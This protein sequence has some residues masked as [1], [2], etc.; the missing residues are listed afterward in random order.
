[1]A[2][3]KAL[4]RPIPIF[5][6]SVKGQD[7]L[8]IDVYIPDPRT[9]LQM[10]RQ[11]VL[12]VLIGADGVVETWGI[13]RVVVSDVPKGEAKDYVARKHTTRPT[14]HDREPEE[15]KVESRQIRWWAEVGHPDNCFAVEY[16]GMKIRILP[17]EREVHLWGI[18]SLEVND[19]G[20]TH[21]AQFRAL[22]EPIIKKER[23]KRLNLVRD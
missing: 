1:M 21:R 2:G 23:R 3:N 11:P 8:L 19:L 4:L 10:R 6:W 18:N 5:E 7:G 16:E 13:A 14:F 9:N 17:I 15:K 12:S 20:Q 22:S